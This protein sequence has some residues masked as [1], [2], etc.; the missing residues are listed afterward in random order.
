MY[1]GR[2]EKSL[3]SKPLYRNRGLFGRTPLRDVAGVTLVEIL[4]VLT[5]FSVLLTAIFSVFQMGLSAWHKT[6][7]KNEL[8][9]EVQITNIRLSK[10]LEKS[11]IASLSANSSLAIAAFLSPVGENDKFVID[12]K[13][14]P[15]WQ[16]YIVYYLNSTNGTLY[17]REI[18]LSPHASQRKVPTPLELY[19]AGSGPHPLGVYASGG[20]PLSRFIKKFEPIVLPEPLSQLKWNIVA[21][22]ERYGSEQPESLSLTVATYLRN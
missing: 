16:K 8:L 9:Q 5:I 4:I 2:V 21:Q 18:L 19:N 14:R 11:T 1:A 17:R 22:R 13:G 20:Q 6:A 7:I 3:L 10:E 15:Q 12:S